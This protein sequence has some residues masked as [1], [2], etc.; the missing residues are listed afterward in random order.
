MGR[1]SRGIRTLPAA[2]REFLAHRSPRLL[3]VAVP[4][5]ALLRVGRGPVGPLD[6]V[7]AVALV[8]AHPFTEWLIHV[9]VLHV[10][11]RGPVTRALDRAAGRSHRRHHEDPTDLT[12]QF[13][14]PRA[15]L[16]LLALAA[17]LLVA[18]PHAATAA[19]AALALTL[20][21]EW[22][23]FLIHTEV[24]PRNPVYRRMHRHHRLH[25]FRNETYWL[26]V[27][28]RLGDRVLGTLPAKSA[29]PVSPTART[30]LAAR[31]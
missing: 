18:G 28:T 3:L 25:H 1:S 4:V 10:R 2:V 23:H 5:A 16:G 13:I 27:T 6:A 26:G 9:F 17:V 22:L 7:V 20:H 8:G 11:A 31:R 19:V 15:A 24:P 29:V 21:Y 30:A 14:H 12:W